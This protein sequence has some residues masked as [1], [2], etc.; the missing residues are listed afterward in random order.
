MG[1]QGSTLPVPFFEHHVDGFGTRTRGLELLKRPKQTRRP[2]DR[3]VLP[4]LTPVAWSLSRKLERAIS[5]RYRASREYGPAARIETAS[6]W[7]AVPTSGL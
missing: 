3:G 5:S 4:Q 1:R 2:Q 6:N 7:R